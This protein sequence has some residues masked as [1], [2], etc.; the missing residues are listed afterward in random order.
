MDAIYDTG[1]VLVGCVIVCLPFL[2]FYIAIKEGNPGYF[3]LG[4][5]VLGFILIG[6]G[7]ANM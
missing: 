7:G 6:I 5:L 4:L 1:C 3:L 2:M